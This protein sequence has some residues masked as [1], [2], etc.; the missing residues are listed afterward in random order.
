M[1]IKFSSL[2][3]NPTQ[4]ELKSTASVAGRLSTLPF[5]VKVMVSKTFQS[6]ALRQHNLFA[7][8]VR[9]NRAP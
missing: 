3:F 7:N 9:H 5:N 4:V 1:N 2:W 8:S 6:S